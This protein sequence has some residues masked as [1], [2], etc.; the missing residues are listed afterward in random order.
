[1]ANETTTPA[2]TAITSVVLQVPPAGQTIS[3]AL[4]PNQIVEVPFDMAEANITLVG[5]DLRLEF[6]GNAVLILA[7]FAAMVDA[8]TSPL[9]MFADGTVMAGDVILTALS[10][11]VP[12]P[13]AGAGAGGSGGA[14]EYED[15]MGDLIAGVARLGPLNPDPFAKTVEMS[16]LDEQPLLPEVPAPVNNPPVAEDNVYRLTAGQL[17]AILANEGV[18]SNDYDPDGDP[19]SFS[20]ADNPPNVTINTVDGSLTIDATTA[21]ELYSAYQALDEGETLS[22]T[23]P[24]TIADPSGLT[25]TANVTIIVEGVNDPPTISTDP[26]NPEGANDVVYE[27][28]LP[29]GSGTG[30]TAVAADGTFKVADPDGLDDIVSVTINGTVIA[31]ADLGNNN[32]VGGTYGNLTITGYDPAT[33]EGT[34]Q[35]ELTQPTTDGAG[36]EADV[37]TLTTSDGTLSSGP[38]MITI[39]IVDDLPTAV[40]DGPFAVTEDGAA[41]MISGNA[42][43][44]DLSGA[45]SPAAFVGWDATA[46]TAAMAEL[47]KY[48]TLTLGAD[49]S[50]QFIL[51]NAL[52]DVQALVQGQAISQPLAYTMRDADGDPST[53][54]LT[55]TING[56]DDSAEVTVAAEGSDSIVY[57][58]GLDAF[59]SA[60]ATASETDTDSF[61][62]FASDGIKSVTVGGTTFTVAELAGFTPSTPSAPIDTGEGW[63]M[64]TGYSSTDGKTATVS[65][66]YTLKA[67]LEHTQPGTD[68][69]PDSVAVTVAGIGGTL[70]SANLT[71]AIYDDLPAVDFSNSIGSASSTL[72][73]GTWAAQT[74]ADFLPNLDYVSSVVLNSAKVN[75]VTATDLQL[76]AGS[77]DL[78]GNL[79]YAGAFT[80]AGDKE[81]GFTLI[82]KTDGT[83][84]V[85]LDAVPTQIVID[86][87][88]Y[89][90]A[91]KASGP[92][93]TYI[94]SYLDVESG[95]VV[96]AK[97]SVAT[98]GLSLPLL[99]VVDA[100]GTPTQLFEVTTVGNEVNPSGDGIG[101]ENNI[102]NSYVDSNSGALTTESL[103]FDPA[104]AADTITLNFKASGAPGFGQSGSEDVLY[105]KVFSTDGT[106]D[107]HMIM[108]DSRYGDFVIDGATATAIASGYGG[109]G[110]DAYTISNPFTSGAIDYIEVTGGF[111]TYEQGQKTVVG[112]TEV[113]LS[114]GF[115]TETATVVDLP[116]EMNF[117]TTI[118]DA[119]GDSDVAS[120]TVYSVAGNEFVGTEGDDVITGT[121]DNDIL[122]GGEGDDMFTGAGGGD[123]F[124]YS[125]KGGEGLD[126]IKDFSLADGDVLRFH[127]V[128]DAVE[129]GGA[130]GVADVNA[131]VFASGDDITI[132]INETTQVVLEGLNTHLGLDEGAHTLADLPASM[133]D[134]TVEP[135]TI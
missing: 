50:Y 33:G 80:F 131:S 21:S 30:P 83:Y 44:N 111:Y 69:L 25:A 18:F 78:D 15:D 61:G 108:L 26:G 88:E 22:F 134:F 112:T 79:A 115:T 48:G 4:Q 8:G 51:N 57:E 93:D 109:G 17:K 59:G 46:N 99:G 24:Y 7:N 68:Q 96:T 14:G 54:I 70:A 102:V 13:A 31:I 43:E 60:A 42:L 77:Y 65:Y 125:A 91:V 105:I 6:P 122:V 113:K 45:D 123:I 58:A 19:I 71:I 124:A 135:H 75:G 103:I 49:G 126:T 106:E 92:T 121:S 85:E 20:R 37:F 2:S 118:E 9:M 87:S 89:V 74:G 82:L 53:A 34:Y 32:L 10:A 116:V 98:E 128:L 133:L 97:T 62:V 76:G 119:D 84:T 95:Q 55:I 52:A 114:F 90:G 130:L 117:T 127:E 132:T 94:L 39:E 12:E 73:T 56:A 86:P 16:L 38:A 107:P 129:D 47:A 29:A 36:A 3:V 28:G 120:F 35:Y 1:M 101:I 40:N 66:A 63:L 41:A 27:A 72:L 110:L 11:E 64:V 104:G 67:A 100:D 5:N 81:V 23:F